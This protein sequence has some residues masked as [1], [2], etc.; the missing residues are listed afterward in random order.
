MTLVGSF[1]GAQVDSIIHNTDAHLLTCS[2][3]IGLTQNEGEKVT[4]APSSP[5]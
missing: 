4:Q 2:V 5:S 3:P 1:R